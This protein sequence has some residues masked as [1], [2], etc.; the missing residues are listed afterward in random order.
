MDNKQW[1]KL[2]HENKLN[3]VNSLDSD[4]LMRTI[5]SIIKDMKRYEPNTSKLLKHLNGRIN[6][7][8][9]DG[10]VTKKNVI[11]L[12]KEPTM[13]PLLKKAESEGF[14]SYY[15]IVDYIFDQF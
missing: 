11:D 9:P 5:D 2:L 15:E 3:E 8:Y 4:Y 14:K 10:D 6:Q 1:R 12:L 7:S 13:R